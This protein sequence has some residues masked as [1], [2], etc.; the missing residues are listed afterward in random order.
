MVDATLAMGALEGEAPARAGV[1]SKAGPASLG[2][3]GLGR[4]REFGLVDGIARLGSMALSEGEWGA[5]VC[6]S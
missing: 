1:R 2:V 4:E 6:S 3:L 5:A